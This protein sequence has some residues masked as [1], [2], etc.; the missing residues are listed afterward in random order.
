MLKFIKEIYWQISGGWYVVKTSACL[1]CGCKQTNI[2]K[3][4]KLWRS[5]CVGCGRPSIGSPYKKLYIALKNEGWFDQQWENL[6]KLVK[7]T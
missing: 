2:E 3:H 6:L 5:E 4:G 1:I 7:T